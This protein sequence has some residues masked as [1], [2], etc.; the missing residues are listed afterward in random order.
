MKL[1][2]NRNLTMAC[3]DYKKAYDM[4]PHLWILE[5]C[6]MFGVAQNVKRLIGNSMDF[7]KT[8]LKVN[9]DVLGFVD[10]NKG[11]F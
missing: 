1:T 6:E 4:V 7:W 11:I 3:V 9:V 5:F 10:I 8:E 2:K